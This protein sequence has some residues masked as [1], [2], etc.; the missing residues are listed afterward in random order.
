MAKCDHSMNDTETG[1]SSSG[2]TLTPQ[3]V[4][5]ADI[6]KDQEDMDEVD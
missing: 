3:T 6:I 2:A 1:E 5:F 4:R